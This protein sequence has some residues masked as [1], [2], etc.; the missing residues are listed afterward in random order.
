LFC[1]L[2]N[3]LASIGKKLHSATAGKLDL[4]TSWYIMSRAN[5]MTAPGWMQTG[6]RESNLCLRGSTLSSRAESN[7]V[8]QALLDVLMP[9]SNAPGKTV[10]Q[11]RK[12]QKRAGGPASAQSAVL[13]QAAF[14]PAPRHL[15]IVERLTAT[16]LSVYWSDPRL[17][18]YEDQIWRIGLARADSHCVLTGIRI[19]RGDSIYRPRLF[20]TYRPAN[21]HLM[22][23]A[24]AA[25]DY[26]RQNAAR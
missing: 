14:E 17:G 23:L 16:T 18:R 3:T 13:A 4:E 24:S 5:C 15:A 9:P 11:Q 21:S 22:I 20:G 8:R 10:R 1:G 26:L 2:A 19:S 7:I 6:R 25:T 12:K